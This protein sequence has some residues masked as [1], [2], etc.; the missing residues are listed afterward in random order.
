MSLIAVNA[1]IATMNGMNMDPGSEA[2]TVGVI[3]GRGVS[4]REINHCEFHS[5]VRLPP[6]YEV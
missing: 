5:C 2:S 6:V 3:G 4:R 1:S